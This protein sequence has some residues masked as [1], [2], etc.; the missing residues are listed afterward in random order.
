MQNRCVH[1]EQIEHFSWRIFEKSIRQPI[2]FQWTRK[3]F[4]IVKYGKSAP[5]YMNARF[6]LCN[7]RVLELFSFISINT[8][9]IYETV[10]YFHTRSRK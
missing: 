8:N 10:L 7:M 1:Y 5:M 9:N 6:A 3:S 2:H 4:F